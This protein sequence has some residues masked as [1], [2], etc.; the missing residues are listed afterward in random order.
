M[1]KNTHTF[2]RNRKQISKTIHNL[3]LFHVIIRAKYRSKSDLIHRRDKQMKINQT[4]YESKEPPGYFDI[5]S[6][7][8]SQIAPL[9]RL[10]EQEEED[11]DGDYDDDDDV[12]EGCDDDVID[13]VVNNVSKKTGTPTFTR[14]SGPVRTKFDAYL[15][16]SDAKTIP[17]DSLRKRNVSTSGGIKSIKTA[18][19][20][21]VQFM[22]A[23]TL[24]DHPSHSTHSTD[25]LNVHSKPLKKIIFNGT[26]PIDDPYSSR[27]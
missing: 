16:D 12:E 10:S 21:C 11:D 17:S 25:E 24:N 4:I 8:Q 3:P 9:N 2:A 22:P 13:N 19:T 1:Q 27:F 5:S 7:M 18:R 6:R 15:G 20:K 26:F 23:P 14:Y